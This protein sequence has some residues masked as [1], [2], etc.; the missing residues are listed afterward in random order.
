MN[1]ELI[2]S[3]AGILAMA[4]WASLLLSPLMPIL[5]E[6][7]AGWT[8]PV[9]L[10]AGYVI[11]TF[12]FPPPTGGFGSFAEVTELFSHANALIAGWIHY[13]AFDLL[14]G[15]WICRQ[16]RRDDMAFWLVA[17]CLPATF[18]FGPAG[19]L[20]FQIVRCVRRADV[21]SVRDL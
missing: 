2:F 3:L 11:M 13:L 1:H 15:A 12:A 18:L 6:R 19:Y 5:S 8:I 16:G 17:P 4:G 14:V 20:M 9:I 21:G 10:S 7:I